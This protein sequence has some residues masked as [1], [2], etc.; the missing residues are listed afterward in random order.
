MRRLLY[1]GECCADST[2]WLEQKKKKEHAPR[3]L[4]VHNDAKWST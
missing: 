4:I 2:Q 3:L 1:E